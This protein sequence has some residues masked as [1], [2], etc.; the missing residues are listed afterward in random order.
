MKLALLPWALLLLATA[1]GRG[2]GPT[3]GAQESCSLRCG[4]L[5]GPCSCHPTCSG[6]GTCCSDFQDFCLEISPYS[7][8][9][10]GGKDFV[11]Q[12]LQWF[13]ATEGVICRFK[14]SIETLG[15]VDS[16]GQVHCVSPLLYESGRIPFTVSLDNG[17]SFPRAGTWLAVHPNK[18]SETEKS[19]L[20]N[21][22]RWQYY[23]TEDTT[24]NLSLTWDTSALPSPAV[25][26][27][28]WGYEE[29]GKPYSGEWTAKWSYLYPLASNIPNSG[30]FTFTPKPASSDYQEWRVGALRITDSNNYPGKKDVQALWTNEHALAWHLSD[31]FREDPVAWA[32][33]QCGA[34]EKLEDEL[35]DFLEELPD[36]PCTLAQARADSGRFHTDYG[37][38]IEQGSVCTY[39]PG[40]VHCVRSVQASPR[41][42]A[43]QQ[44]CYTADGTQLLTA[45]SSSGS[46][47]D[48]GHDWGAPP[49]RTPPRVP[50]MSHWLYDVL[51][52]YY[53][54][55]WAPECSRYMQRR[56]SNDC[57]TYRPPR[58]ASAFGDPHF[59]TFDGTK[60]TFNGRGEYVL[61][62]AAL[63][64][65]RVQ[66]RAQPG[67][68]SNGTQ[69]RGTG[70]TAVAVQE[71]NSDVVEVRLASRAGALEVLLNQEVLSFAEQSWMDLKGMF[72]SVA[73]EDR[74]SVMLASGAGLEVGIQGPFLS[75]S[76]LLP[77][78][79]LNHTLGLLG[80]LNNDP[81]DDFTLRSGQ[82]LPPS[83]SPRDLFQY[84]A[85]WAVHNA[86]SLLTYDS[87]F[88]R[89][90]FLYQPRHDPTFEPLFPG[91]ATL[92]PSQAHEAAELCGDD[93][94]CTFDVAATGSLSTGNATRV[95]HQLHQRRVQSLQPVVSCGRLA[96]PLNGHKDSIRYL[97]GSTVRFHCNN[98]YSLAGADTSTC[99]AD[100]TWSTPTPECQPGRSYTVLFG[101]IFGGLAVV[102][103]VS[104]AYVLLRRRKG[105]MHVWGSQP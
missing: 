29:T 98:G 101:I 80:T 57:R 46:T 43:G 65:L 64:D 14:E 63:T 17:R 91:E 16:S 13:S 36:C 77:E 27:E 99:Q 48:R 90:N 66:A 18:V 62:E 93:P 22:T 78:K 39:H 75:V 55:L 97:A 68:T 56:P 37:C 49:F 87:W 67:V 3:A 73:A 79:F 33:A 35:P 102:A 81:S 38:D 40:A 92:S 6:L 41:Y 86:S 24:G 95:A 74:V 1:P 53:C 59:V 28:L 70:L 31:D 10:M 8:S 52:F 32:L 83:T 104:L 76:V 60:F 26:I 11:V 44:C 50:G 58:L 34:W 100:G 88:L 47:P 30:F 94:F 12:K 42:G 61:L 82:V 2:P 103:A 9:L 23:G 96:P 45:D 69:T 7:G 15:H 4:H 54:C 21:E 89:Q 19:H 72:L 71:D 20:V 85:S 5:E 25:T 51:S 84:G 105:D